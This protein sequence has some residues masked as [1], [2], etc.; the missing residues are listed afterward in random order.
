MKFNPA[1]SSSKNRTVS[2]HFQRQLKA[3]LNGFCPRTGRGHSNRISAGRRPS[4]RSSRPASTSASP[5]TN[6]RHQEQ[7]HNT[8]VRI[9]IA[10]FFDTSRETGYQ[11][12][13]GKS[14][15]RER[16]LRPLR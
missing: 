9:T 6:D 12:N 14:Y 7:H 16:Q 3:L 10:H 15:Q 1:D 13:Q 11:R 4:S 8:S 5:G 2:V